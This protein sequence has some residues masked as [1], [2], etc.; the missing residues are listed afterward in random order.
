M[1]RP[2][3][4][5]GWRSSDLTVLIPDESRRRAAE[6]VAS[7]ERWR[8]LGQA[9]DILWGEY[10]GSGAVP[11]RVRVDLAAPVAP[12]VTIDGPGL[13]DCSCPSRQR[14]SKHGLGLIILDRAGLVS[15]GGTPPDQVV[16]VGAVRP[17]SGRRRVAPEA[18]ALPLVD[19]AGSSRKEAP[20]REGRVGAGLDELERWLGDLIGGGLAALGSRAG[21]AEEWER[22]AGRLVDAQAPGLARRLRRAARLLPGTGATTGGTATWVSAILEELG[23]L[24]LLIEGYRARNG[25][26]DQ[27]RADLRTQIGWVQRREEALATAPLHDDWLVMG[28]HQELEKGRSPRQATALTIERTWLLGRQTAR[29]ALLIDYDQ[30]ATDPDPLLQ[31][32]NV[33]SPGSMVSGDLYF[34]PSGWPLRGIL[35]RRSGGEP[36]ADWR[37]PTHGV[38]AALGQVA[39]ALAGNPWLEIW[40]LTLG[41]VVPARR[42]ERWLL[43]DRDGV[44]LPLAGCDGRDPGWALLALGGGT[45]LDVFGEWDGREFH[46]LTVLGEG[47]WW[48]FCSTGLHR[49]PG[50]GTDDGGGCR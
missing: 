44:G 4:T 16:W 47:E 25:L 37:P 29:P 30:A 3:K 10:A 42:G 28:R 46:P 20:A 26:T 19:R 24:F 38:T 36:A 2:L 48:G 5:T 6:A 45:P 34:F 35:E 27:E 12:V 49:W 15:P 8:D 32:G 43:V 50:R 7:P 17:R 33:A 21:A 22:M 11:Y 18:G 41:G 9:G 13:A 1:S 31:P 39:T 14:P 23:I 40:P